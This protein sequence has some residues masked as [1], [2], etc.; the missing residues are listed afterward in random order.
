MR[1]GERECGDF[2]MTYREGVI[3]G[4]VMIS[5]R[6]TNNLSNQTTGYMMLYKG[7]SIWQEK[8]C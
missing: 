5:R 4:C 3:G 2:K 6:P 7:I 1:E 8:Q